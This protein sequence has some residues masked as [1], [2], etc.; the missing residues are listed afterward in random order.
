MNKELLLKLADHLESGKLK[1]KWDYRKFRSKDINGICG[2]AV[3]ELAHLLAAASPRLDG[4]VDASMV[5][6]Y[7]NSIKSE[8]CELLGL[9]SESYY[10]LF[11]P[12]EDPSAESIRKSTSYL[13][14]SATAPQV[15]AL[16]REFVRTGGD[17]RR[18]TDEEIDSLRHADSTENLSNDL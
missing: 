11:I 15:A 9:D 3:G 6:L 12:I 10:Y 2:C 4:L 13:T 14:D 1:Y 18:R 8:V 5:G 17:M 7:R 16:I